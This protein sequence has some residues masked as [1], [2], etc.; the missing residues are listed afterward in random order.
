MQKLDYLNLELPKTILKQHK[1]STFSIACNYLHGDHS[2]VS[3]D[4]SLNS[5]IDLI[6]N[7]G[8]NLEYNLPK[9]QNNLLAQLKKTC[10]LNIGNKL[11]F[12]QKHLDSFDKKL[13]S[14]PSKREITDL[15]NFI[16]SKPKI[17]EL[18]IKKN[19]DQFQEEINSIKHIQKNL[20]TQ[21]RNLKELVKRG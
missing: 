13:N 1:L 11:D 21:V 15:I 19:L 2:L 9:I 12:I 17:V 20:E 6:I 7:L 4:P 18:E 3:N 10:N 14:F 5:L 16:E 8:R